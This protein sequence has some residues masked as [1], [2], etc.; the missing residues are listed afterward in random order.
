MICHFD[1]KLAANNGLAKKAEFSLQNKIIQKK[2]KFANE[3]ALNL[4]RLLRQSLGR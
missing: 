3:K 1:K 4:N 2:M